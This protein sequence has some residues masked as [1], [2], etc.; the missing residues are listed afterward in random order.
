MS[1]LRTALLALAPVTVAGLT[2]LPMASA[3]LAA[4]PAAPA[5]APAAAPV[6]TIAA[7]APAPEPRT[8]I[9]GIHAGAEREVVLS[10]ATGRIRHYI[11]PEPGSQ[12]L[13]VLSPD[14]RTL[15]QGDVPPDPGSCAWSWTAYDVGTGAARP[16]LRNIQGLESI[17][18]SDDGSRLAY[19]RTSDG[20]HGACTVGELRLRNRGTGR[21]S[22]VPTRDAS[23]VQLRLSA[24]GDQLAYNAYDY[25]AD[26]SSLTL[27]DLSPA[28]AVTGRRTLAPA[29]GCS[30]PVFGYRAAT[31][32][33]TAAENCRSSARLVDFDR[34]T[35]KRLHITPLAR[36]G[37][38]MV[39][40]LSVD[41]SGQHVA[42]TMFSERSGVTAAYV[43]RAGHPVLVR[44]GVYTVNW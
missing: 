15:Y 7:A 4:T 17:A 6:T 29:A 41:R 5:A 9:G 24:N 21:E 18:F 23:P 37:S 39:T 42:F 25:T 35:G 40:D 8:L 19:I 36:S 10:V 27:V 44:R 34:H 12:V 16:A 32:T 14:R 43:L 31:R 1:A 3:S 26:T 2:A 22:V 28:G 30:L 11:T 38:P 33:V 20:P 13:P